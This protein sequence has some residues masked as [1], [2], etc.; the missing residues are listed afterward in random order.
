MHGGDV[1]FRN[2]PGIGCVFVIEL[3]L[4]VDEPATVDHAL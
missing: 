3:P 4:A 2:L 1:T